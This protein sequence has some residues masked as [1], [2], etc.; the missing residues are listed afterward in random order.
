MRMTSRLTAVAGTAL[1]TIAAGT[2]PVRADDTD[3]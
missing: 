2:G 3:I 1:L